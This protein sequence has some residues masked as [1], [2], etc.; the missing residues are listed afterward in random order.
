MEKLIINGVEIIKPKGL[1]ALKITK[2]FMSIISVN[3]DLDF[4]R[5]TDDQIDKLEANL[6]EFL[7]DTD[8]VVDNELQISNQDCMKVINYLMQ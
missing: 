6:I 2:P 1:K 8:L 5:L 3:G 4:N 7:K